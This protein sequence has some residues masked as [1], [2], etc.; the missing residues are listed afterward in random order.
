MNSRGPLSCAGAALYIDESRGG[1]TTFSLSER[2]WAHNLSVPSTGGVSW[3]T[4]AGA[5][6]S[7]TAG[8]SGHRPF[9]DY[10]HAARVMDASGTVRLLRRGIDPEFAWVAAGMGRLGVIIDVEMEVVPAWCMS[11]VNTYHVHRPKPQSLIPNS[12]S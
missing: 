11:V 7:G 6:S 4:I 3:P 10:I 8:P 12:K 9:L 2:L 1:D 5:L